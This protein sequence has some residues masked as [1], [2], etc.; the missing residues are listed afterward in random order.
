[1]LSFLKALAVGAKYLETDVHSS[2]DGV[3]MLCHD[4]D[5]VRVAGRPDRV[6]A[7]TAAQ[8]KEVDLGEGQTIPTLAEALDAFP[9]ALFNLDIKAKD[10][11]L[12]TVQ[13]I[14]A[15]NA[16]DRILVTSFDGKRRKGALRLLPETATSASSGFF[17]FAV[18][19]GKLRLIPLMRLALRDIDAV[20]VPE[21]ALGMKITTPRMVRRLHRASVEVHVWTVNDQ[22]TMARL[23]DMGVDGLVTDRADLAL[24]L[25]AS[26]RLG[27]GSD[28]S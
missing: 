2:Q 8:L 23:L 15:A 16:A 21:R 3:A 18:I 6:R 14:L 11:V 27:K 5:L 25:I 13:A 28:P 1:M 19:A 12:P 10:A 9:D 20:Q 22:R 24:E 7:L 4:A 17:V 26:R